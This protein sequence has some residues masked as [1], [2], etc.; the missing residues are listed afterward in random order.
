MCNLEQENN[1]LL[2]EVKRACKIDSITTKLK[3]ELA[4]KN[5]AQQDFPG[6]NCEQV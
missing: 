3:N 6:L 4:Q 2:Q 1:I 5:H